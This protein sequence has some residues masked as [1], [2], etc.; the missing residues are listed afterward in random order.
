MPLCDRPRKPRPL[1]SHAYALESTVNLPGH[2]LTSS[3]VQVEP[4]TSA[5]DRF[6]RQSQ[7]A[8]RFGSAMSGHVG[9][10]HVF[11]FS[12]YVSRCDEPLDDESHLVLPMQTTFLYFTIHA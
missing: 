11:K 4:S 6:Q 9:E 12:L 2:L 3:I 1:I 5:S 7:L 8:I 10:L